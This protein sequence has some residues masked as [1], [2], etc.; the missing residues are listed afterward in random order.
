M[1]NYQ[2][3]KKHGLFDK[4]VPRY[5]SYPPA[6][7]FQAQVGE[8]Q[9][10]NWLRSVPEA[11]EISIYIHIPFCR[12]LCWF[13]ACR[14]QGTTSTRPLDEYLQALRAEIELVS[15]QLPDTCTMARLHFGGGTP[16]ILSAPQMK[17]LLTMVFDH[18]AI[19]ENFE[20]SV[21][22]D[23]TDADPEVVDTLVEW[24]LNRASIGVQDFAPRVQAAIGRLQSIEQTLDLVE[25][26]RAAGVPSLNFDL[27][28]GLPFQTEDSLAATLQSVV[29][30]RPNRIALYGYAHVPWMSKRQVMIDE[31]ALPSA[32]ERFSLEEYSREFLK[33]E[34]YVAIGTDHFALRTDSIAQAFVEGRLKRNFQGFTDDQCETLIGLG[35]SSI[36]R[37]RQG[38]LQNFA[39]TAAYLGCLRQ[40][41]LAAAKGYSLNKTDRIIGTLVEGLMCYGKI[42][43]DSIESTYPDRER[44]IS[45]LLSQLQSTFSDV[46]TENQGVLSIAREFAPLTRIVAARL[47]QFSKTQ[48]GRHSMAI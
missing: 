24:G 23:P 11:E 8:K 19:S 38:F 42:D 30:L 18:F 16:T 22:I 35:A 40:N 44:Q 28:Y 46:L 2:I 34:D 41:K 15:Q 39:S 21:E 20:F 10:L 32:H 43:R 47:D 9:Q 3:F 31:T 33:T 29:N 7:Q 14:T 45:D 4:R 25:R 12:R 37:F 26:L 1:S 48:E 13:C 6:N 17:Q 27:L 5:T 36:S